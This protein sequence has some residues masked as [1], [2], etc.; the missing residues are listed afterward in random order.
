MALNTQI[1]RQTDDRENEARKN[2]SSKKTP[3]NHTQKKNPRQVQNN[4][5][6]TIMISRLSSINA[7]H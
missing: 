7:K 5:I 1:F 4:Q 2:D 3:H 6:K